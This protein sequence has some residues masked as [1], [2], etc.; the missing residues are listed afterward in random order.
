M[1]RKHPVIV[2]GNGVEAET[3]FDTNFAIV[4]D[5]PSGNTAEVVKHP[6]LGLQKAFRILVQTGHDKN[7]AA[8]AESAAEDL[9]GLPFPA[10]INGGFAPV[11]LHGIAGVI[12]QWHIRLGRNVLF[13]HF[14]D[15][16]AHNGVGAG[17]A[18]LGH[19]TVIDP[20]GGV[21]LLP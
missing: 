20:F 21:R 10:Q 4:K 17:K 3:F 7:V 11:D 9:D 18:H 1:G 19:Q 15:H 13:F 14:M 12:F 2:L 16:T 5:E 6:L 8:V